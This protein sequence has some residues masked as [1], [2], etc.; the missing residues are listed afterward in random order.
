MKAPAPAVRPPDPADQRLDPF[1]RGVLA[2]L[3]VVSLTLLGMA[4][5]AYEAGQERRRVARGGKPGVVPL[6]DPLIRVP[7]Q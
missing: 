4:V 6:H 5:A 3:I 2:V 1:V 7:P